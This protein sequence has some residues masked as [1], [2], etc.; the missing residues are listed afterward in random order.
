MRKYATC[1]R[2]FL[3]VFV[4]AKGVARKENE[5]KEKDKRKKDGTT[6]STE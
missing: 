6:E 3:C 2:A 1:V 5:A 4:G